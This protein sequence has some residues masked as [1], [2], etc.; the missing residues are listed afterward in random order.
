[1]ALQHLAKT[2]TVDEVAACV[3][4]HGHVIIDELVSVE[5]IDRIEAELQPF[6]E[7][8]AFGHLSELGFG[9]QRTGSLIARSPSVH[10]LILQETYLG[11]VKQLLSHSATVQL[12]LTEVT[13]L[14]P[15]AE[16]QFL[17]QDEM[18]YDNFPFPI[19]Y[20]IFV[21][22]LWA[23]TDYTEKMGATRVVPGS[24][25]AGTGA[26]FNDEDSLPVEMD[27]GSVLLFSSKIYHGGGANRSDRIRRAVDIGFSV[28]WVRQVENQFLSC[29]IE[30]ARTL[31]KELVS[32]MGY[33]STGGYGLV[34]D[35]E[36][37]LTT[38]G[39]ANEPTKSAY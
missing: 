39:M 23:L 26:K 3:R 4:E 7:A 5:L 25:K 8:T 1:M 35:R 38:L 9:T 22:S 29:P 16:A 30:I 21:N 11:A 2:A 17:H 37:A 13:S 28:G 36:N 27:R 10:E 15:G 18:L 19:D 12:S 6:F 20:E 33:A 31:P 24:H 14:A 32:L 34:G